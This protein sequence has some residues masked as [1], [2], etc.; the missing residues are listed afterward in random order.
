MAL[1][2]ER[3][4]QAQR[5]EPISAVAGSRP[6]AFGVALAL[7]AGLPMLAAAWAL[8]AS[9]L[10]LSREMTWDF[11]FNLAGAWH[12][13]SGH[14]AHVDFHDP[15][16]ELNFLLTVLGFRLV[17]PT[18]LAFVMG[19]LVWAFVTFVAASIAAQRRLPLA[20]AAIFTVFVCLLVV[21]PA[22]VGDPPRDYSFAMSY[23]RYGWSALSVLAL[24]LFV[25]PRPPSPA[26]ASE[27]R[28]G[29]TLDMAVVGL[30]LAALFY[31]KITYFMAGLATLG[32][33]LFFFPHVRDRWK[34]WLAVGGLVVANALAPYNLP[35]LRDI[36][37]AAG[38]GKVRGG[39]SVHLNTFLTDPEG[40][41]A[42]AAGFVVAVW[43]W[44]EGRA[45]LRLPL[46]AAFLFAT[47]VFLL[48]QNHQ[49]QGV[50]L[51]VM[52]AFLLYDQLRQTPA[53]MA[54]MIFPLASIAAASFGLLEY[55]PNASNGER[56]QAVGPTNLKRLAVPIE[57]PGLLAAFANGRSEPAL[58]SRARILRPHH[59][60]TPT[61]YVETLMEAAGLFESGGLRPGGIVVLDQVNP[62]P[63]MLGVAPPRG[64][65]L[66]SGWGAPARPAEEVFAEADHVLIPKFPTYSP[67]T[68][69][70]TRAYGD[71]LA[72]H[73]PRRTTSGS[74]I[75]LSRDSRG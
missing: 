64:G 61:E 14:V 49:A 28:G 8:L 55:A 3:D 48:T 7:L 65:A 6:L 12:L 24:I 59:E 71:Y 41:A 4:G 18:P 53:R 25:P 19:S 60:L 51:G 70:A 73:F 62:L 45:P 32:L 58:L 56:F 21:M 46:A 69:T 1:L 66:W 36:W 47:G 20:P 35:Y 50:P 27:T 2:A 57:P 68:E 72:A 75:V 38:A 44:R 52:I 39:I 29:D 54:L 23:N 30:V 15:V 16:G 67:W 13:Q 42:Y 9:G 26:V 34:G 22:N 17:G 31:L 40:N 33:A 10:V 5:S 37:D 74:W 11:L 43:L 63:F